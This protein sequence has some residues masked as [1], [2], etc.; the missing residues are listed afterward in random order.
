MLRDRLVCGINDGSTQRRLLSEPD[1]TYKK[2][3]DIA[4][5]LETAERN[6]QDL[7]LSKTGPDR[8]YLVKG[9]TQRMQSIVCYR[10]GSNHRAAECRY[11]D[12]T[13]HS[14]GKQGHLSRVCRSKTKKSQ[15]SPPAL[16]S[17]THQ[18]QTE[19]AVTDQEDMREYGEYDLFV[20]K[21]S[22]HRPLSVT[23]T[24]NGVELPLEVDTGATLSIISE[25][26]YKR[27]YNED[28][29]PTLKPSGARLRTYTG[30]AIKVIGELE[31]S[32]RLD[33]QQEWKEKV[34][35]SLVEIG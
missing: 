16:M 19:E 27:L 21:N 22:D 8:L 18:I 32:V 12:L 6:V 11:K 23:A 26:T 9:T 10:C 1:L 25:E 5:A 13:C 31:V 15:Q 2:A 3:L 7:Q 35:A 4:Q 24:I 30:E 29:A 28:N 20:I 17:E 33:E 14:C 34:P